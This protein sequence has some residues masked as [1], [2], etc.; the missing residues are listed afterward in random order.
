MGQAGQAKV[1]ARYTWEQIYS[2]L[3]AIYQE[4]VG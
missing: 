1:G 3:L 2:K 4:L